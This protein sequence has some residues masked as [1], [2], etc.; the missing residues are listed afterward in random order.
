MFADPERNLIRPDLQ[1]I[2]RPAFQ[3]STD[4]PINC[5]SLLISL[6]N[7][8]LANILPVH[9]CM[10]SLLEAVLVGACGNSV[11]ELTVEIVASAGSVSS[12]AILRVSHALDSTI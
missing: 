12:T 6:A 8:L 1:P 9:I 3:R 10:D 11:T 7:I 2:K 5:S 4:Q